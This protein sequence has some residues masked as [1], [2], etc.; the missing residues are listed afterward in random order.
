MDRKLIKLGLSMVL[1]LSIV[2]PGL[3][4]EGADAGKPKKVVQEKIVEGR[5]VAVSPNF[6]AI[7]QG[8]DKVTSYEMALLIDKSTK[9]ERKASIQEFNPGEGI[10]VRYAETSELIPEVAGGEKRTKSRVLSKV[11]KTIKFMSPAPKESLPAG[12]LVAVEGGQS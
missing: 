8:V 11:A 5:I 3:A 6:L 9:F 12:D 1:T 10:W 7:N 2:I 4:A